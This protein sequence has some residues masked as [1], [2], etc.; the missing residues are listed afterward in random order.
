MKHHYLN[1]I[2]LNHDIFS[3]DKNDLGRATNFPHRID[4]KYHNQQASNEE[5]NFKIALANTT[6]PLTHWRPGVCLRPH[7]L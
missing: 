5:E 1:L 2:L 6:K 3:V 7:G 4:L